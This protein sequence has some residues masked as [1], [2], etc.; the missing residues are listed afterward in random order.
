MEFAVNTSNAVGIGALA[1]GD[2]KYKTQKDLLGELVTLD[3]PV[4]YDCRDAFDRARKL[5]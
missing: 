3:D 4:Y 2:L 5:A 1:I